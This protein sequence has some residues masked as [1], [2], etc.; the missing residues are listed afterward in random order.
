MHE[1]AMLRDLVRKAEEVSAREPTHRVTRIRLWVGAR[2]HL[3]GPEL[4][5]HWAYAV[6][7]TRL[8]GAPVD[9]ETSTDLDHP[10]AELVSL[11]SLDVDGPDPGP[12][13][14]P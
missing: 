5:D 3:S 1:E 6:T 11:R 2:S 4:R 13:P 14:K 9:I 12:G 8:A 10:N 7:G